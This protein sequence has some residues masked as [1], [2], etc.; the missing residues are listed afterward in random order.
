MIMMKLSSRLA[1]AL[2]LSLCVPM[3]A[4]A[5]EAAPSDANI[6]AIAVTANQVDIDAGNQA[7]SKSTNPEVKKFAQLMVTDHASVIKQAGD[8]AG[9]L[10]L[11]PEDNDLSKKLKKDG[12]AT[13]DKMKALSG[14]EFDKAYVA[15]EVAYHK[16]VLDAL[17]KVLIPDSKNAELKSLLQSVRPVIAQHLGHAEELQ[18]TLASR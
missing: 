7:L 3:A 14:A 8:L 6:A 15:N 2:A 18:K 10:K 16:A 13:A 5:K 11:T 9:K 4:S 12:A 17:D 1:F